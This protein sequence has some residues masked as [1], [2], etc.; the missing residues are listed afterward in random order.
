M[1]HFYTTL[2]IYELDLCYYFLQV[3][4]DVLILQVGD[5]FDEYESG[6]M[7]HGPKMVILNTLLEECLQ[8]GDK[9]LVFR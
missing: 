3:Q 2:D 7:D 8:I 9:V 6:L 1:Y 4:E 5:V